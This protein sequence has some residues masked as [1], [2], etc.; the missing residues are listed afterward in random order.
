MSSKNKKPLIPD[1][2]QIM[3][4]PG[5]DKKDHLVRAMFL[6]KEA[7]AGMSV[8]IGGSGPFEDAH[9]GIYFQTPTE[10][11]LIAQWNDELEKLLKEIEQ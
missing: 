7:Q 10:K 1:L 3:K 5:T 8:L 4:E 9:S 11:F 2:V 6:L